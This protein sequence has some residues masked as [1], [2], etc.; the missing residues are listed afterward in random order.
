MLRES[1]EE[2][3]QSFEELLKGKHLFCPIDEQ[4]VYNQLSG[5]DAAIWSLLVASG[6][7]KVISYEAPDLIEGAREP[8]YEL[9]LT[10]HEVKRMFYKMVRDWFNG[11][12]KG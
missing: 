5:N 10:N 8:L 1:D 7:L 11:V 2:I 4:I 3:K 9:A 6:Y 12:K